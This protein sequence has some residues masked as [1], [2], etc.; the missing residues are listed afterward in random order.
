MTI[1][2]EPAEPDELGARPITSLHVKCSLR[3]RE[4]GRPGFAASDC[5]GVGAS[6]GV[7]MP[8]G[9]VMWRCS[10]HEALRWVREDPA[11]G[12]DAMIGRVHT[13]IVT[14]SS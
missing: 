4:F 11:R 7:Q 14:R 3:L 1:Y 12:G 13:H 5:C 8:D 9:S 6:S 10:D 2:G